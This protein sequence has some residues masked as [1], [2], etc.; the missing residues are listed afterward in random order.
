M[1]VMEIIA[2]RCVYNMK[3]KKRPTKIRAEYSIEIHLAIQ[4]NFWQF[5]NTNQN[6]KI[7][8]KKNGSWI[9]GVQLFMD[10]LLI[11]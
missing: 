4:M 2:G 3:Q 10:Y 7:I 5:T 11:A 1:T 6:D 8:K 9:F